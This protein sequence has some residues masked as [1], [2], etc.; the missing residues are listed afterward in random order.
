M[1]VQLKKAS[2]Y[3]NKKRKFTNLALI[4]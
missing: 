3:S 2:L 4:W 1:D